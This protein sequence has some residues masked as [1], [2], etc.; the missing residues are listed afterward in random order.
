MPMHDKYYDNEDVNTKFIRALPEMYDEK[1]TAIRE[2]N[3]LTEITLEAVYGKLRAYELEKHQ[4]KGRGEVISKSIALVI[5]N[6]K[7]KLFKEQSGVNGMNES[8]KKK[9]KKKVL[10]ESESSDTDS[11][12]EGKGSEADMK[13]VMTI[14]ARSFRKGK[15]NKR[16]KIFFN[17]DEDKKN[18]KGRSTFVNLE[19]IK[20]KCFNCSELGH[21]TSE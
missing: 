17:K 5:Q 20:V 21:F 3:D 14:F 18:E 2:A 4:R 7:E 13:E 6:E 12:N 19:K 11:D 9:D 16:S 15:F 1:S 10:S 8:H